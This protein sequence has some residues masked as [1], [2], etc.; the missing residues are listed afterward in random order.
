[1]EA[2]LLFVLAGVLA[3]LLFS[4]EAETKVDY[5]ASLEDY[6]NLEDEIGEYDGNDLNAALE[7]EWSENK[8][9]E[10]QLL[11]KLESLETAKKMEKERSEKT[12]NDPLKDI[13]KFFEHNDPLKVV[14][15]ILKGNF[16]KTGV[17]DDVKNIFQPKVPK[18]DTIHLKKKKKSFGDDL[19][20][21]LSKVPLS[22]VLAVLNTKL[23]VSPNFKGRSIQ[24][25]GYVSD[26][27]GLIKVQLELLREQV[28]VI[29]TVI[30]TIKD[31]PFGIGENLI[32]DEFV[33]L[34]EFLLIAIDAA[35]AIMDTLSTIPYP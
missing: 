27:A 5:S 25:M 18:P 11:E 21:N 33:Q 17:K 14:L 24:E 6:L 10:Q 12:Q 9:K 19:L 1:M 3:L 22:V 2:R 34:V 26:T 23:T 20:Q 30:Q 35:I 8:K 28:V 31:L 16:E 32:P 29:Q 7:L 15:G 4:V 13:E